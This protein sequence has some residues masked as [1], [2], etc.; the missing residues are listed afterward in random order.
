MVT[1]H[2]MTIS[3]LAAG[4]TYYFQV[5][6]TDSKGNHG[7]GGSKFKTVGYGIAGTINPS[8]GGSGATITLTGAASTTAT[9][10]SSGNFA[11]AGLP[12]GT[13]GVAPAHTGYTFT[14]SSQSTTVNGANV[15]G[16]NFTANAAST[17][18]TITTQPSS[19]TVTA[20]QTATF[21]VVAGGTSPLSYQWQKNGA[22]ISGATSS[23]YTTSATT[24]SD[25]GSTFAVV[26][27]NTAGT[28]TSSAATLTVNAAAVAPAITTQ[29][30]NQT[31]TAGQTATFT[32]AATGTAPL[33]YQW[34]KNGAN[35]SGATSSSYITPATT[36]TDSGSTFRAVVT[37]TAG[38]VTSS[39]ATL[40]V[41]AAAVAPTI[42][43][44]PSSQTVT[45]AQTATFS[46]A[47][48]GT[49]PLSYQWSKNNTAISG[50]TS[51]N[52]TTPATATSDSGST[53]TVMVSNT[54]GTVTS[55]AAT[56]TVN[57]AAV[58]P[59]I[60]AQ[61]A[62]Q[63]VTAGQTA[64]F[65]VV[66]TGTSPL[67][68]QWQ[69]NG[70]SISGATS[71]SYTTAATTSSDS[72]STFAVVVSNTA[73][74]VTSSAATLTVNAAAVAPAITTQPANQT[75]T[76]GQT[77]SFT[78]VA[79]GTAPLSYQWQKNG[80]SM[81]GATSSSYTTPATTTS[82][83]GST[84]RVVV[85]NTAGTVTSSAATLTVNAAA[86]APAI[87]TQPANQTVTAG[88][89]ASFTVVASGT[90]PLSYQWQKNGAS[91]S[92]AT[93]SSYATAA[94]T[95]SDSGSTFRVVVTNTA[96]TVTSSA[97][98][99][100]VNAAAVAPAI[101][102]QPA[103]QTVTAGQTA[104]FTVVASG[105]APLS[106]QWQKN[107]A[108]ISGATSSSYSTPATTTADSGSTFAVVVS[109]TAGT[110]TS[111]AATLTVNADTTAPTVPSGLAATAVSSS[112]INLS[113]TAS[114]DNVGVTGY[115]IYRGGTKIGTAPGTSYQ[116]AGLTASTTYNYNVSAFDAAG[117]TSAQSAGASATTQ[118]ATSGGGIPSTLGWYQIPNT[119]L[120][121]LCGSTSSCSATI[122]AW[123][124]GIADTTRNRLVI[125]G[126][127]HT[128]SA[129]N[130]LYYLDL[131]TLTMNQLT[132]ASPVN[133][134]GCIGVNPDGQAQARHTYDTLAYIA[135]QDR[136]WAFG[137][138]L[139]CSSGDSASDSW[140]FSFATKTWTS[141]DPHSGPTPPGN[142]TVSANLAD[143][144]DYDPV[145][146]RV[147]MDDEVSL[148]SYN[149]STNTYTL[150]HGF[151]IG[152]YHQTA[153]IDPVRRLFMTFGNNNNHSINIDTGLNGH[154][155]NMTNCGAMAS[156]AYPGVAYDPVQQL[157]VGW[158]GGDTVY[159]YN[160]TTDSCT[161]VNPAGTAPGAQQANGTYGRFRY[162][163][164][165]GVFAL[166]N[167]YA[168]NAY[169]LRLT[170]G[171]S[172]GPVIS[173][174]TASAITTTG[175]NISWLTDVSATTQV[176]YGTTTAYG[177]LTT[178]NS[179]LMTSHSQ[180]LTGLTIGTLYHYRVHSKNSAG[181]E[182]ISGD[183]TFQTSSVIDTI[184]PTISITA[185]A[186]GATVSGPVAVSAN[187]TDNVAVTSVQ[188]F[189]DGANLGLPLAAAP[190]SVSWDSTSTANGTHT[191]TA[192][193]KDAAGNVGNAVAVSVTVSNTTSTT[194][195]DFQTRCAQAGV[196]VCQGFDDPT[197]FT[198]A[199]WPAS[200]LYPDSNGVIQGSMDTTIAAS[201]A[202]SLKFTV[203]SLAAAN[204]SGYWR[205]LFTSNLAAGP[206]SAKMFGAN[207]TFYLQFRQRFSIEYLTNN[208]QT[209][210]GSQTFWKQEIMSNDNSTC[211]MIELTTVNWE[212]KRYPTMYSQ[213]GADGFVVDLGN[214]DFL[215]EQGNTATTG[216]NCHYQ[217]ANNTPTSCFIYPADTWVTFY[218]KVSIGNWGQPNS[219]IQAWVSVAGGPYTE[220]VNMQNHVLNEDSTPGA[221][222]DMVTL[223]TYMTGRSASISAGPT[224]YTWYDELIVST[225]P[226]APP[227]N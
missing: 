95:T 115:N 183:F 68:Y 145:T 92:G 17:A 16:V 221:D 199:K 94:T 67:G 156:T 116:D 162:F 158:A 180:A 137:G 86:V 77:A 187:A 214:S 141:E 196:I 51:A 149:Y 189:L 124:G 41:N 33:S 50:A 21:A 71:S 227:N 15:A 190:Y 8:A 65:T 97:A 22:S 7:H 204:S 9:A 201:G 13:Y 125:W 87:T 18:P 117:N 64:T 63:T 84:F 61:P 104:S 174:I 103:N 167:D 212:Q 178:L 224:A 147:F 96:G 152:D 193:A 134:S 168:Q 226:V 47:A 108:S 182:S 59:A 37:N 85:T 203:P 179:T 210:S 12:N 160:P 113:W 29:P 102:T 27:S 62:N 80:A 169:T 191:L 173:G 83:S 185:P 14:P 218:Y 165:L 216:Y 154:S 98:T 88:Q 34:Q 164:A 91:I 19:Q 55:S 122:S 106:Y 155:L 56:L 10:D 150:V 24:T 208:W 222:Y 177:T 45:A 49:A 142:G 114:T 90:A 26:V 109:N 76:A 40:T 23:S 53:F 198:P 128:D 175:S 20:G 130:A 200:G 112:Q 82:D 215:E 143:T 205:Q 181:I 176:E 209:G 3:G 223:L 118:A 78:V 70:A 129:N 166:V 136:L 151:N 42:T 66:A 2:Q 219:T 123:S 81:S 220:F 188:F 28:V 127:G 38:T 35:I 144:S 192:Q 163:P 52:Y 32:V 75:V 99:L 135:N 211:G 207:S 213:C 100:T 133:A 111:S 148:Y 43:T 101:T 121:A 89:T 131:N 119:T 6:S 170:S 120:Q 195:Q 60:T 126:G 39:A 140:T 186:N 153:V 132:T 138:S 139:A 194:L 69:K 157:I 72:G 31:V 146:G 225:T 73:G 5:T 159:L 93:S 54:A 172:S 30:A 74:T 48:T 46:V 25:T 107:G 1:S 217:T 79:S 202:G 184:P 105:T 36:T 57:A 161:V 58:A 4:T 197:V 171:G 206:S 110:L 44:Q 11:F